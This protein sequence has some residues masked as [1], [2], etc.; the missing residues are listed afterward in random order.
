[1]NF[2]SWPNVLLVMLIPFIS[3]PHFVK[4]SQGSLSMLRGGWL[5]RPAVISPFQMGAPDTPRL[6]KIWMMPAA[7]SVPYSV[8]AAAPFRTSMRSMSSAAMSCRGDRPSRAPPCV[9]TMSLKMRTPS[10]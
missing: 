4:S 1:M 8:A 10:T 5:L 2:T 7:A 9:P 6:V 3:P